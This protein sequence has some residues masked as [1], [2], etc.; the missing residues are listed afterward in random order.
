M[1]L[2]L[3]SAAIVGFVHS[4]APG[5]W[6]PVVLMAKARRW[7]LRASAMGALLV[8]AGHI[9]IST[10]IGALSIAVGSRV[11]DPGRYHDDIEKYSSLLLVV[12]GLGYALAAWLS[13]GHGHDH[14]L[15]DELECA[16]E[17][18]LL[19]RAKPRRKPFLFLFTLGLTPCVAVLPVFIASSA[20]GDLGVVLAMAAFSVGVMVSI[21]GSTLTVG[22]GAS[23]LA[24]GL[25]EHPLVEAY[26][27]VVAGICI[28]LMGVALFFHP[29]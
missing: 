3:L 1:T 10:F 9:L 21:L 22:L 11:L 23:R 2:L 8:A 20:R 24:G 7:P 12:F 15:S 19:R 26:G 25:L 28:L 18:N 29:L 16:H 14:G 17:G 5:H 27:D 6:L 4:L 13:P